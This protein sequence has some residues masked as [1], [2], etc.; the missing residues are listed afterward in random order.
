MSTNDS[1]VSRFVRSVTAE[2]ALTTDPESTAGVRIRDAAMSGTDSISGRVFDVITTPGLR[3]GLLRLVQEG[4]LVATQSFT[5][6]A[7]MGSTTVSDAIDMDMVRAHFAKGA[8]IICD[9][10]ELYDLFFREVHAAL[11]AHFR[12]I[13]SLSAYLTPPTARGLSLHI[14]DEDVFV[15]Q[16]SGVK[17]WKVHEVMPIVFE[18]GMAIS[19]V[20]AGEPQL[21]IELHPGDVLFVPRGAPHVTTTG[22]QGSVHLTIGVERTLLLEDLT[23]GLAELM[24]SSGLAG[25]PAPRPWVDDPTPD[26]VPDVTLARLLADPRSRT[27]PDT[28]QSR[29]NRTDAEFRAWLH[30]ITIPV[31]AR[32]LLSLGSRTRVTRAPDGRIVLSNDRA[33]CSVSA[34]LG[35]TVEILRQGDC[36]PVSSLGASERLS[37]QLAERLVW[38]GIAV[39]DHVEVK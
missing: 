31:G 3:A 32:D 5:T 38:H 6:T 2:G 15:L 17:R 13:I 33:R 28:F 27:A 14:D 35:A 9:G 23:A 7:R 11:G 34:A 1:D 37:C 25:V 10:L 12:S 18:R 8:T 26:A 24:A 21:D 39:V 29:R 20:D 30:R 4:S 19:E 16:L 36:V 22:G